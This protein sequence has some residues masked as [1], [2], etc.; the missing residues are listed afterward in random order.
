MFCQDVVV[1]RNG[2][3]IKTRVI[4]IDKKTISYKDVNDPEFNTTT[5]DKED[6][7][8]IRMEDGSVIDFDKV[9]PKPYIGLGFGVFSPI[10]TFASS[11]L[12]R[13][14]TPGYAKPGF[15]LNIKA[16]FYLGKHIGIPIEIQNHRAN[17]DLEKYTEQLISGSSSISISSES[18]LYKFTS[19]RSGLMYSGS[20]GKKF[21]Y[22]IKALVGLMVVHER[23]TLDQY[24]DDFT[25]AL[26]LSKRTIFKAALSG[27]G[28]GGFNL[29][30]SPTG[31]YAIGIYSD[32]I[33]ATPRIKYDRFVEDNINLGNNS[34]D[35]DLE[36]TRSVSAINA[37]ISFYWQFNRRKNG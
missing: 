26:L 33:A 7:K 23:E 18:S 8:M 36:L 13:D 17:I 14:E 12:E 35:N 4:K 24:Y 22:D 2:Q 28:G 32:I 10:A 15:N 20:I 34:S 9:Y 31:R 3:E 37:G 16:G 5:V 29:R 6:V 27:C 25:G 1:K 21:T 30:Y 19:F 11:D